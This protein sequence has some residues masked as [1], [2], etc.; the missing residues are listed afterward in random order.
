MEDLKNF[1]T[2]LGCRPLTPEQKRTFEECQTYW[3]G[4]VVPEIEREQLEYRRRVNAL[5]MGV[6]VRKKFTECRA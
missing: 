1:L 4:V 6:G 5:R 3:M 2:K